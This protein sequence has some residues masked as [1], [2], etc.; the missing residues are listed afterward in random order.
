M[1][2]NRFYGAIPRLQRCWIC[3]L[4]WSIQE[5]IGSIW[6]VSLLIEVTMETRETTTLSDVSAHGSK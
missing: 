3:Q 4:V 6:Y 2:V 1:T 5:E